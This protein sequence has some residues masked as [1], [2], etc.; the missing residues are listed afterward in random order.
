MEHTVKEITNRDNL[1]RLR[2]QTRAALETWLHAM[3]KD[4][5]SCLLEFDTM[6]DDNAISAKITGHLLTAVCEVQRL[7]GQ[8]TGIRD[9]L[10]VTA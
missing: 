10:E 7:N 2:D 9:A 3:R 8:L 6:P 1:L 4:A 5:E